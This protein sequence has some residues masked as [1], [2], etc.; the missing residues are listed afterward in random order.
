MTT[1]GTVAAQVSVPAKVGAGGA[2]DAAAKG[3][4]NPAGASDDGFGDVLSKLQHGG[5]QK[6]AAK[7]GERNRCAAQPRG[8]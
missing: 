2:R 3:D 7:P 1:P 8:R 4:A 6:S 5:T